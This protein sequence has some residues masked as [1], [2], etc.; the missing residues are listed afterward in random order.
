MID[1]YL[2]RYFLGVV[3]Q[4]NFSRA[5]QHCGVS[6]PTLSVGISKLEGMLNC[7]LF[8]RT[9]RRVALTEA[10]SRFLHHARRIEAEF[11]AAAMSVVE[12]APRTALRLGVLLSLPAAKLARALHDGMPE[13]MVAEVMEGRRAD[14]SSLLGRGRVDAIVTLVAPDEPRTLAI[15][16]EPYLMALAAD[17]PLVRPD[18]AALDVRALAGDAM[19]VRRHCE[20]LPAISSFFTGHGVRPRIAARTTNDERA[21][22]YVQSGLGVTMMP[23]CFATAGVSMVALN[24]F[25]KTRTLGFQVAEGGERLIAS[26]GI[27]APLARA[28]RAS[29]G[30]VSGGI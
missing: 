7:Q 3:E 11:A 9:N 10:G 16:S 24:G 14:L 22:A 6:Q 12:H 15:G 26:K 25:A 2:L 8:D 19:L 21:L 5:A 23:A 20:A 1:R 17:H 13:G 18:G 29:L 27:L 28:L 30:L 4:G